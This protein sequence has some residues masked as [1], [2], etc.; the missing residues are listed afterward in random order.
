M[1]DASRR[2]ITRRAAAALAAITAALPTQARA[3]EFTKLDVPGARCTSPM[4]I[5]DSG[6]V[7]GM[8]TDASGSYV[9]TYQNGV[10]TKYPQLASGR[11][12]GVNNLGQVIGSGGSTGRFLISGGQVTGITSPRY[13]TWQGG[14]NNAGHNVGAVVAPGAAEEGYIERGIGGPVS[15]FK[16]ASSSTL[17]E[18]INDGGLIVGFGGGRSSFIYDGGNFKYLQLGYNVQADGISNTGAVAGAYVPV[19]AGPTH[20]FIYQPVDKYLTLDFPA[21]LAASPITVQGASDINS[22]GWVVGYYGQPGAYGYDVCNHGYLAK[23]TDIKAAYRGCYVD[24]DLRALPVQLMEAGA[25]PETCSAAALAKGYAYAGVQDGGAC[26]AGDTLGY[27]K[28]PDADCSARCKA[29]TA[30]VCGGAWRNGIYATGLAVPSAVAPAYQGC[31]VDDAARGLPVTL[32]STSSASVADCVAAARARGLVYAG[33]QFGGQCYGGNELRYAKAQN[34][35]ECRMACATTR[36]PTSTAAASGATA[37]TP[38]VL[39]RRPSRQPRR[40]WA[41]TKT[42]P[43]APCR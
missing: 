1:C 34:D 26:F 23:P 25:T 24:S 7:A 3:W 5:N 12:G 37:S 18:D 6:L 9:F 17:G 22:S 33:L 38:R 8:Y 31:Y 32:V 15:Y 41:A 30:Q 42:G 19:S 2:K 14:I 28:K 13:Q 11:V 35:S 21:S 16:A 27:A 39:R 43:T 10:Y 40:P 4:R 36:F 29:D 20:G